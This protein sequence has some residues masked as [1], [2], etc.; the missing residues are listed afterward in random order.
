MFSEILQIICI[1]FVTIG[2]VIEIKR[3]AH[4]GYIFL[5][6]A[7]WLAFISEKLR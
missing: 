6:I 3:K 1:T 7:G 4:W 2:I 5:T